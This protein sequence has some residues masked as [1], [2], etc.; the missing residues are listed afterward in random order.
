MGNSVSEDFD[1]ATD[2]ENSTQILILG[3]YS[4]GK[5]NFIFFLNLDT[6]VKQLLEF[7][8]KEFE[9]NEFSYLEPIL[10]EVMQTMKTLVQTYELIPQDRVLFQRKISLNTTKQIKK[11]E[12]EGDTFNQDTSEMI[13]KICKNEQFQQ[14][15]NHEYQ[16]YHI[17]E[18]TLFYFEDLGRFKERYKPTF[19]DY[20]TIAL[21]YSRF[22]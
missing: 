7:Y 20:V 6:L 16:T 21:S 11:L 17:P 9:G 8:K 1:P 5:C 14:I 2:G 3:T 13:T 15:L 4:S 10:D 22:T 19:Q 12:M 18:G